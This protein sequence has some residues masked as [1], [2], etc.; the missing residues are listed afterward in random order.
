MPTP[1]PNFTQIGVVLPNLLTALDAQENV[2]LIQIHPHTLMNPVN[3][4]DVKT[5][6]PI[7]Y[8]TKPDLQVIST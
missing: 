4:T 2:W 3:M 8:A 6:N 5:W 1:H 7:L